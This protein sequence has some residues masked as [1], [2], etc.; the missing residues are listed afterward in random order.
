MII[1]I[2]QDEEIIGKVK[3]I[4]TAECNGEKW[5]EVKPLEFESIPKW[6]PSYMLKILNKDKK[7]FTEL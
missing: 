6:Y 3:V 1:G 5:Y 2:I 4:D 7:S